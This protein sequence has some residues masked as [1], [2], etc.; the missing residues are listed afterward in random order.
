ML[1]TLDLAHVRALDA[2]LGS[3]SFLSYALLGSGF[4]DHRAKRL[5]GLDIVSCRSL[6]PASLNRS[7][8]HEQSVDGQDKLNHVI[9]NL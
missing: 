8:L 3:E 9:F 6:G 4:P 2:R 5:R 1:A 7:L